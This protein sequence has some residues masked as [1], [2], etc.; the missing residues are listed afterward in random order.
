MKRLILIISA[1]TLCASFAQAT[2]RQRFVQVQR[3][4]VQRQVVRQRVVQPRVVRQRVVVQQFAAPHVQQF[5]VPHV[6]QFVVPSYSVQQ[7]VA[8]QRVR[9]RVQAFSTG[10]GC[11][12][13][14][15]Y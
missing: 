15:G 9:V 6:Q 10:G 3:V 8:P 7:F 11:A 14:L 4:Q 1:L 13:M 2:G 5:V 12:A